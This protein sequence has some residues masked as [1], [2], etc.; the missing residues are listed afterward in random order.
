MAR[1][2]RGPTEARA[3]TVTMPSTATAGGR[4]A[5]AAH[6]RGS[7]GEL[8]NGRHGT[9]SARPEARVGRR[10]PGGQD[11]TRSRVES[12]PR[13][14]RTAPALV[15]ALA[16]PA[17]TSQITCRNIPGRRA[18]PSDE[19]AIG[20]ASPAASPPRLEC[21]AEACEQGNSSS[22][23]SAS[24]AGETTMLIGSSGSAGRVCSRPRP[25]TWRVSSCTGTAPTSPASR[26]GW[27]A[28]RPCTPRH[29]PFRAPR[30]PLG[31]ARGR[32]HHL[33]LTGTDG[34]AVRS[35]HPCRLLAC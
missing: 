1:R 7:S 15:G 12:P 4:D 2:L 33:P 3:P 29:S 9:G 5:R 32:P 20:P 35:A 22:F 16:P 8:R 31:A 34:T 26:G 25:L 13:A 24:S 30:Q 10:G 27:R 6:P 11:A 23:S 14:R 21:E 19:T 18:T 28:R 17:R